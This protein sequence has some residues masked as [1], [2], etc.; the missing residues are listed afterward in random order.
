ME[1]IT[2][3]IVLPEWLRPA[4]SLILSA[5]AALLYGILLSVAI[6]KTIVEGQPAFSPGTL[7][8]AEMLSALVGSVVTAGF[9]RGR[10]PADVIHM[11]WFRLVS[12]TTRAAAAKER[13]FSLAQSK[14]VALVAIAVL[15]V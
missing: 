8:A 10:Q 9:A 5:S 7:R 13:T 3:G 2:D 14:L 11:N 12:W 15:N 6:I 1:R 4:V